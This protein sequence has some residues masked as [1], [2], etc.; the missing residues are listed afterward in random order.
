M[1][2]YVRANKGAHFPD[3]DN[4]IR[5]NASDNVAPVQKIQNF[6]GGFK[7]QSDRFYVDVSAYHRQF[8]GLLYQPTDAAGVPN[9]PQSTYGSDSQG[10]NVN[11]AGSQNGR[12]ACRERVC[13]YV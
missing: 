7:F 8:I 5:G 11:N 13:Q 9:G 2:V 4:G 6:E 1:S 10:V 3:C 12:A